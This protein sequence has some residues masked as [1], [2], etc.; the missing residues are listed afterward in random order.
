MGNA[1]K[2]LGRLDEV[3]YLRI[4]LELLLF[5]VFLVWFVIQ[6]IQSYQA[7]LK[8]RP[9]HADALN[10]LANAYK[11]AGNSVEAEK[12]YRR[13]IEVRPNFAG[14]HSNLGNLLKE[15]HKLDAALKEYKAAIDADSNFADAYSNMG[16]ALKDLGRFDEAIKAYTNAIELRPSFA[17][18][19]GNLASVYKDTGNLPKAIEYY[20]QALSMKKATDPIAYCNLVHCL[21]TVCD[22]NDR[23]GVFRKCGE[24]IAGQMRDGN[25]PSVQPHHALVYPFDAFQQHEIAAHYAKGALRNVTVQGL[26][27]YEY[28]P[29]TEAL[30][31][32]SLSCKRYIGLELYHW[33]FCTL[34]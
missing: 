21:Q 3:C 26:K 29:H 31:L 32:N 7:A 23:D 18:A 9:D 17:D 16:N 30:K 5:N 27:P 19:Y 22:W 25:V 10:N 14:A 34:F 12:L 28:D 15:Q 1:L 13:A 2:L 8:L 6:A 20:N 11:E 24:I 4:M 33:R